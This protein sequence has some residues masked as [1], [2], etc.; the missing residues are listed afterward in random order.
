M[1]LS[2]LIE[3]L[4]FFLL[5]IREVTTSIF[6]PLRQLG[7]LHPK[8]LALNLE[9]LSSLLKADQLVYEALLGNKK[10]LIAVSVTVQQLDDLGY[11]LFKLVQQW[12][13]R[14]V[15]NLAH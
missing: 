9:L 14:I 15:V 4:G 2:F 5:R 1:L 10:R 3:A 13:A 6:G 11:G 8:F 7:G 12:M